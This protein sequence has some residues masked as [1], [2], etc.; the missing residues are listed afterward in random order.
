MLIL[1]G[2]PAMTKFPTQTRLAIILANVTFYVSQQLSFPKECN[3]N[4]NSI[5]I[6]I[7]VYYLLLLSIKLSFYHEKN[8]GITINYLNCL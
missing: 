5:H 7:F 1:I 8:N 3:F 4:K 6:F 2:E